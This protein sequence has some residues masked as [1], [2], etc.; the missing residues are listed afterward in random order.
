MADTTT[1]NIGL[2]IADL[3]DVF[4]FGAHV[5]NNFTVIDSLMGLV[6]CTSLT[7]PS[8]TYG[9]QGIYETDTA[10]V[11]VNT[12]TKASPTW[13][14]VTSMMLY[15]T[16]ATR[17]TLGLVNGLLIYESDT[18][19]LAIYTAG[20]WRYV[21]AVICTSSTRPASPSLG[22]EI[23]ETDTLRTLKWSGSA[24]IALLGSLPTVPTTTASNGTATSGTTETQDMVLGTYQCTLVNGQRYEA[25]MNGL[26]GSGSVAGDVYDIKI[27]D[28]GSASAPTSSSTLIAFTQWV[29][30]AAGGAGQATVPLA[31]TFVSGSSGTHTLGMFAQRVSGTGVF[32][33]VSGTLARELFVH[34]LGNS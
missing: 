32:T 19:A 14:Y 12:N 16:S 34:E 17:P 7:R 3:N 25:K 18:K 4:N 24:W 9:G 13:A 23:Y 15:V 26:I 30:P 28:S 8:N 29:C 1:A 27:R 6:K 5:E 11:A 31:G 20:A 22:L 21:T 33:P 10:R 2:L